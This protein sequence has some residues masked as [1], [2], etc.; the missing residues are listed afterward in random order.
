[1]G[2]KA[3]TVVGLPMACRLDRET[4]MSWKLFAPLARSLTR[5]VPCRGVRHRPTLD[6]LEDRTVLSPVIFNEVQSQSPLTLS[7]TIGSAPIVAQ[8]PGALTTTY[9]GTFEANVDEAHGGITFIQTGN[10]FC[11]A[12]SGN[13]GPLA[14]GSMGTA[15]AIYGIQASFNQPALVALR[16]FHMNADTG[17]VALPLTPN[18]DGSFSYPSTQTITISAGSGTYSHPTFGHGPVSLDGLNGPN[19]AAAGRLVD[20]GHGHLTL[21]VPISVTIYGSQA[22]VSFTLIYNGQIV[23]T[24]NSTGPDS[25]P[26]GGARAQAALVSASRGT[27]AAGTLPQG[28]APASL[29]DAT[30]TPAE[31]AAA[32]PYSQ[33]AS[34]GVSL[35]SSARPAAL[36]PL[37]ALDAVLQDLA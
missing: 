10:D 7:G 8:G 37:T 20:D 11:G 13:W 17:G 18:G 1:L 34:A 12:D 3:T 33:T 5:P 30:R 28:L 24:G 31:T 23:G 29:P 36:D 22:G 16:D 9:F 25:Q 6:V 35:V 26:P 32:A 2:P 27:T 14:D 15:P 19:Q 21:T 4:H